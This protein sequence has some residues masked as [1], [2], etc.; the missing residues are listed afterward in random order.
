MKLTLNKET[1]RKLDGNI[2]QVAGGLLIDTILPPSQSF[3][4]PC[5]D[6]IL[7]SYI[8]TICGPCPTITT[9]IITHITTTNPPT[10]TTDTTYHGGMTIVR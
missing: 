7:H 2:D 6:P 8:N 5:V 1:L 10:T 9:N 4:K 3:C